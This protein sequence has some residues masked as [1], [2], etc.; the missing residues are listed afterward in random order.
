MNSYQLISMLVR[1]IMVYFCNSINK[2]SVLIS[3]TLIIFSADVVKYNH[4]ALSLPEPELNPLELPIEDP[5]IPSIPR[6]LTPLEQKGLRREL[7]KLDQQAQEQLNAGNDNL[8]F[9]IWYRELR[10]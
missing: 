3:L 1:K 2:F 7:D 5:L 10:L 8:A 9:E 6:P 4:L